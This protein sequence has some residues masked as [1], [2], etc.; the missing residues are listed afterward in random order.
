MNQPTTTTNQQL[1]DLLELLAAECDVTFDRVIA[2]RAVQEAQQGWPGSEQDRW[3]KWL[4]K[5]GDSVGLR[6]RVI[7][8]TF[9]QA[10]Q[11]VREKT[12]AV[13]LSDPRQPWLLIH[14]QRRSKFHVTTA[15]AGA[16][17][18][19]VSRSQLAALMGNPPQDEL[20]IWG[21]VEPA[22][23]CQSADVGNTRASGPPLKPLTRL[24]TMLAAERPDIRI[25]LVFAL[26]VGLLALATPL[27]IEMLVST[28]AFG[29]SLQPIVVLAVILFAF[30]AFSAIVQ[31]VEKYVVELI[32]RR[33]FV[34]IAGDLAY[35]LPRV[36]RDAL[37]GQFAP[38][39]A[40]RFFDVATVQ[41]VVATLLVDGLDLVMVTVAGMIV[42]A[43]FHPLLLGL[44][45]ILLTLVLFALFVLGRGGIASS[46]KESKT[47]YAMAAWLEGLARCSHAHKYE[48]GN[49]FAIEH[50]DRITRAYLT[51]RQ[52]HF[53]VLFRQ[54]VFGLGLY[55]VGS[56]VLFG[57][58]GYLV[59]QGQLS[60][61][62]LVAA[63]L[64][65][66][67]ILG[68]VTKLGKHLESFYDLMASVDKLGVLFDLPLERQDGLLSLPGNA[69]PGN[70]GVELRLRNLFYGYR[71]GQTVLENINLKIESGSSV[72][73]YG[74]SGCGKSTL[75]ELLF[76]L[77]RATSGNIELDG[78][79]ADDLRPDVLR[80]HVSLVGPIEVI[81]GTIAENVHLDRG[82]VNSTAVHEALRRVDLL[83]DVFLLPDGLETELT[84]TG[85]PLSESQQRRMVLAR[86][87][88][89]RP[90]LLIIDTLVDALPDEDALKLLSI[91]SGK[92]FSWTLIVLSGRRQIL[93]CCDRIV[94]LDGGK[95]DPKDR[96]SERTE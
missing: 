95:S 64:I 60:L 62:Q 75:A 54:I 82:K 92:E 83:D 55:A 32:Q 86:A 24:W 84:A 73:I 8:L 31:A 94:N 15:E 18:R 72:G 16:S 1:A 9:E 26:F 93:D 85:A 29:H 22:V 6:V 25:V 76:G 90:R 65:V 47:K 79:D 27:A 3:W 48:G 36:R 80:R 13:H 49:E 21:A 53:R 20:L 45:L 7:E 11:S 39:L 30:L 4:I 81:D 57:V 10:L 56:A 23:T 17:G 77:R 34:R 78:V 69:L 42:L 38:E 51:A 58:G 2:K 70:G 40:N 66:A 63:E 12:L 91:L 71:D 89:G 87:I 67:I 41:K 52:V 43:L 46:I 35:R 59:I 19:W 28:V 50:A 37:D 44:Q 14:K 61:G 96:H 88:A 33:L 5:A 68:S 74:P